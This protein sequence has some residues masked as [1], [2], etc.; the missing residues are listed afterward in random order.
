MRPRHQDQTAIMVSSLLM[1]QFRMPSSQPDLIYSRISLNGRFSDST[2]YPLEC[3]S[4]KDLNL[5]WWLLQC[6]VSYHSMYCDVKGLMTGMNR[7]TESN[8]SCFL[9][10]FENKYSNLMENISLTYKFVLTIQI[11][12]CYLTVMA[13]L[14]ALY[15]TLSRMEHSIRWEK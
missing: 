4:T 13:A 6:R 8:Y 11:T 12:L 5:Y 3:T 1:V 7:H 9:N 14:T 15:V 10:I 2:T